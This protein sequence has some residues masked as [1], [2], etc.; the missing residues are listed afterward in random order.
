[1]IFIAIII[2]AIIIAGAIIMVSNQRRTEWF[3]QLSEDEQ[4]AFLFKQSDILINEIIA[5]ENYQGDKTHLM[6]SLVPYVKEGEGVTEESIKKASKDLKISENSVRRV[7][8]IVHEH[9]TLDD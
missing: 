7:F 6:L 3:S 8:E 2:G 4:S 9:S 1:M 5:K